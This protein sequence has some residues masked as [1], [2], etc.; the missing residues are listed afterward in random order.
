ML[1]FVAFLTFVIYDLM[2]VIYAPSKRLGCLR[3]EFYGTGY[4]HYDCKLHIK[5]INYDRKT[6]TVTAT[7]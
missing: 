6:F 1:K 3:P 2:S 5:I 4:C 7:G